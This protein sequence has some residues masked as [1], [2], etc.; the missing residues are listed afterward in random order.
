MNNDT[1]VHPKMVTEL[2]K[3]FERPKTGMATKIYHYFETKNACGGRRWVSFSARKLVGADAADGPEMSAFSLNT[4]RAAAL[5]SRSH[6]AGRGFRH[7]LF[8]FRR[9]GYL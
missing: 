4:P 2:V 7:K 1:I 9:L 5:I 6:P 8:L 3:S